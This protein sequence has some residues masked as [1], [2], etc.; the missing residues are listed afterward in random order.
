MPS[1]SSELSLAPPVVILAQAL[2]P[3]PTDDW[4]LLF[5]YVYSSFCKNSTDSSE[6]GFILYNISF[7]VNKLSIYFFESTAH[8]K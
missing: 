5:H 6:A 1:F 2:I 4:W 8:L 3:Q 7:K